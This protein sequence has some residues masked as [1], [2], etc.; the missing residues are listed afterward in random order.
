MDYREKF[1]KKC[2]AAGHKLKLDDDGNVDMTIMDYAHHN[3]P[4]CELCN[5]SWCMHCMENSP[6]PNCKAKT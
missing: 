3:G 5:D 1:I 4:G 6:I 2:E